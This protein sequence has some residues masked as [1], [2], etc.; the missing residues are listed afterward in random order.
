MSDNP[1]NIAA[2]DSFISSKVNTQKDVNTIYYFALFVYLFVRSLLLFLFFSVQVTYSKL[3]K[4]LEAATKTNLA[5]KAELLTFAHQKGF[6][7]IPVGI[8][9]DLQKAV[10]GNSYV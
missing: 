2:L 10:Y 5:D 6:R 7:V 3:I 8:S 4:E 1:A 9:T